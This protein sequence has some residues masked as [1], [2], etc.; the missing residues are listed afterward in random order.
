[1]AIVHDLLRP[2][3]LLY[4]RVEGT[5]LRIDKTTPEAPVLMVEDTTKP[6]YLAISFPPQATA[7]TAFFHA[8]EVKPAGD[9][10]KVDPDDGSVAVDPLKPPGQVKARRAQPSRIVFVVPL[11]ARIPY[12]MEGLLQW[13]GLQLSVSPIAA[14]GPNPTAAQIAGAPSI[15]KP[16]AHETSLE[17]PYRLAVSPNRDVAWDHRLSPFTVRGKTELWHTRIVLPSGDSN[18][19]I[20]ADQP[21]PLRAIWSPDY[22]TSGRPGPNSDA[23][24]LGR[25]AMADDDRHQIVILT[26]A[27]QGYEVDIK[28][29]IAQAID[30][31]SLGIGGNGA[32]FPAAAL[33]EVAAEITVV[34][35]T[36]PVAPGVSALSGG[37]A[38]ATPLLDAVVALPP[39]IPVAT[40][41]LFDR[42]RP[43]PVLERL[44]IQFK[45]TVPYIPRPFFAEQLILSSLGGWL[46]SR[47][48]W[49]PPRQ[50]TPPSPPP[51]P[52]DLGGLFKTV[53]PIQQPSRG[54]LRPVARIGHDLKLHP[55]LSAVAV[56]KT[57]PIQLDLSEWVH[58]ASQGRDHYVRIVYEGELWPFR[59]RAALIKVTER[60]F[61]ESGGLMVAYLLQ[62]MFIVVRDPVKRFGASDRGSP[63]KRVRLT[64]LVTPDIA[65]PVKLADTTRSFWVEVMTGAAK[66]LFH[67]H[68]VGTDA[69]GRTVDF[70]APMMFASISDTA[71]AGPRKI[72]ARAYNENHEQAR[73]RVPG[74]KVAFAPRDAASG[75]DNTT[76]V[77]DELHFMVD[78]AGRPPLMLKAAV[79]I[80]QVEE[81]L[82]RAASTTIRYS[83]AY[84]KEGLEGSGL[85]AEIARQDAASWNPANPMA[86]MVADVLKVGFSS[87]QAGGFATPNMDVTALTRAFGPVAGA[88]QDAA[89]GSFD[90]KKYFKDGIAMLFGSFD[91]ADLLLA[92]SLGENAPKLTTSMEETPAGRMLVSTL[93]WQPQVEK[94]V[95]VPP[96][97]FALARFKKDHNGPTSLRVQGRIEKPFDNASEATYEFTGRLNHFRIG[98]LEAVFL[99]FVDFS[100][101]KRGSS[102]MDVGVNL[103]PAKPVEFAGDL[104][105]IEELRKAI[106]PDLFGDGP[107]LDL[108]PTG[109]RAGFSIGLPP[110]AVGVFALK[111]VTL[112]AALTLPFLD[113]KPVFDF[114]VSERSRPFL[115]AV[116]IFGGGGFFRLQLD[117]AGMKLLEVALEFGA[118]AAIDIGVASGEVHMM[119]G[120][121]FALQRTETSNDLTAR[122]T[123]FLRL[124][125]S[126]S[127][128]GVI[129]ISVEFNLSF[130]YDSGTEKAYGRATLTVYV[131]VLLF[132]KS[133]ELVVE[134]AFGGQSGDP[135][136]GE[137]FTTPDTWSEY[138]LAYA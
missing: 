59:H 3:D 42:F 91:L 94:E 67:F 48:N 4:V 31:A 106:P 65:P 27:F 46:R 114:N 102:K 131:E 124:G 104:K 107:S 21:V 14:I 51:P 60:K 1:M 7:E 100:F 15:K 25:T 93:D 10:N 84:V 136:F 49:T 44:P 79:R 75:A 129:R 105:F 16:S 90:P 17:L 5:N 103:D 29:G 55:D 119:A 33:S 9:P 70:T 50:V 45:A 56:P 30:N 98:V 101:E 40:S 43:R 78:D 85:F 12:S 137:F 34:S 39:V 123:G 18:V 66:N 77:A 108:S 115:L 36:D 111:D 71:V 127:V 113:G 37:V 2:D 133:V 134:R 19:E 54:I 24:G 28:T 68:A 99:N 74:Q 110:I 126:L 82:G 13:T 58:H 32:A 69:D 41:G 87:D 52:F 8:S 117:T 57:E 89:A 96:S 62:R 80:P 135:T 26:S 83:A 118:T 128:L 116:G 92:G 72:V 23:A 47:G 125:G 38:A 53:S 63:F 61:M 138:A 95:A 6:G 120:I 73:A 109:I 130:T 86:S 35:P 88:V 11:D 121:Y 132:S 122:L 22:R 20:S 76:L 64:T 97:G 112:G 81:L